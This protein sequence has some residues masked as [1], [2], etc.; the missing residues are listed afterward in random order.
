MRSSQPSSQARS[1]LDSTHLHSNQLTRQ[2]A[3]LLDLAASLHTLFDKQVGSVTAGWTTHA[4]P[5]L[6]RTSVAGSQSRRRPSASVKDTGRTV[7]LK[8]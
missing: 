5:A 1:L 3:R 4:G 6:S 7:P 8:R 2:A